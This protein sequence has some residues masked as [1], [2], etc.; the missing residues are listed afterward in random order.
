[1]YKNN[2]TKG[3]VSPN[4]KILDYLESFAD[5]SY[6]IY[7]FPTGKIYIFG[8]NNSIKTILF[9]HGFY[10]TKD[11][12]KRFRK[13]I[14]NEIDTAVKFLD[15]YLLGD[16]APYP[17]LDVSSFTKKEIKVYNTLKRV[18]FGKTVSYKELSTMSGITNGA[19]FIG[20][21]MAKNLF[22]II[23]PCHRVIKSDGG[24][25]NY[26]GGIKTKTFLLEHEK[27]IMNN[28]NG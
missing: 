15:N 1:M 19:R 26:G 17:V 5:I 25:G 14:T 11:I 3:N 28:K 2:S 16:K 7:P 24:I 9:W 10:H 12:E 8:D 13:N 20:N 21:A 23:I 6:Y 22:P 27:I 4:I 18:S